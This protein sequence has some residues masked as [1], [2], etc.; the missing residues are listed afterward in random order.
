MQ[1]LHLAGVS[2]FPRSTDGVGGS[3]ASCCAVKYAR[4]AGWIGIC[5]IRLA[6]YLPYFAILQSKFFFVVRHKTTESQNKSGLRTVFTY[7][8][9]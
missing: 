7:E 2:V 8:I 3:G 6:P 5:S 1:K 9:H 4:A